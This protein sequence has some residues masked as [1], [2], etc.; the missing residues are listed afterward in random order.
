MNVNFESWSKSAYPMEMICG[1][2]EYKYKIQQHTR[3]ITINPDFTFYDSF[4]NEKCAFEISDKNMIWINGYGS[5]FAVYRILNM[6]NLYAD[7]FL[8]FVNTPS[9]TTRND[10]WHK[11]CDSF[12]L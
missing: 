12:M 6:D 5:K 11:V 2:W 8:Y 3:T 1:T 7:V 4:F 9:Y 10:K